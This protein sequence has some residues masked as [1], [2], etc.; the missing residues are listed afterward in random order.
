M[1]VSI[2]PLRKPQLFISTVF[3]LLDSIRLRINSYNWESV[4]KEETTFSHR[5]S[6][7]YRHRRSREGV[8]PVNTM[9]LH[10]DVYV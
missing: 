3:P 1:L 4:V 5:N 8:E 9:E 10:G 6:L 2:L 7:S